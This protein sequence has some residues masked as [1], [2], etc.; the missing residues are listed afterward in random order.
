MIPSVRTSGPGGI[1]RVPYFRR[2]IPFGAFL[3]GSS[4]ESRRRLRHPSARRYRVPR[5]ILRVVGAE[6]GPSARLATYSTDARAT[7]HHDEVCPGAEGVRSPNAPEPH[8]VEDGS[9]LTTRSAPPVRIETIVAWVHASRHTLSRANGRSPPERR[10]PGANFLDER[11]RA[12]DAHAVTRTEGPDVV[13]NEEARSSADRRHLDQDQEQLPS[14]LVQKA[15]EA[16]GCRYRS[17]HDPL[18][19]RGCPSPK[20]RS[21]RFAS[22]RA[23]VRSP[24][25]LGSR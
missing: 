6:P 1:Q 10:H 7:R 11:S 12:D 3:R 8:L 4:A 21:A 24:R 19:R 14:E 25:T 13:R 16:L 15:L 22:V 23:R 5:K 18:V 20:L 2:R 9:T 17:R